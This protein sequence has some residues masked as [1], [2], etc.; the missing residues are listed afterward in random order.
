MTRS[1]RKLV[2]QQW[3]TVDNIA[4]EEDGGLSFVNGEPFSEATNPDFKTSV[5]G[6]I[7]SV[8]TMI[9]GANTYN[10]SKGY[11]P[12]ADEQG[13]YG[14][15]LNKLTKFVASSKLD[16]APWGDFPAA[17]VT[18]DPVA[19]IRELKEQSG[20]DIWLWGSLILMH[21]LL[22]AGVVDEVRMLVCPESRGKGTRV[23]KDRRDLRVAEARPFENGVV[24]LRYEIK[25]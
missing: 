23:F 7:D 3:V 14:E 16:D 4:A 24:L 6:L 13:E 9:L 8:D 25:K 5:M 20:K 18:R 19:T 22:D 2:V 1:M 12:Y 21:F 10:Q 15:K 11:W 17:T